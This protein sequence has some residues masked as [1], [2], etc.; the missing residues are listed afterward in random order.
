MGSHQRERVG[1]GKI[2]EEEFEV[3]DIVLPGSLSSFHDGIQEDADERG[4]WVA[5]GRLQQGTE[6]RQCLFDP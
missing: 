5:A 6:V 3:L 4:M 1:D 2:L